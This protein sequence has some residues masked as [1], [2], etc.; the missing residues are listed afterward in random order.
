MVCLMR[1]RKRGAATMA[2][3][4]TVIFI[5]I[6]Q[7]AINCPQI[8]SR[9]PMSRG[10]NC[11]FSVQDLFSHSSRP[12][13]WR[14][15][16]NRNSKTRNGSM[17]LRNWIPHRLREAITSHQIVRFSPIATF[18]SS[19]IRFSLRQLSVYIQ[20][21]QCRHTKCW[22]IIANASRHWT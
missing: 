14:D 21:K 10:R 3:K 22:F 2:P 9:Q 4:L 19:W 16:V 12:R 7:K 13:S 15:K 17:S 18:S 6:S 20:S 11:L 5:Y 1:L 8:Y